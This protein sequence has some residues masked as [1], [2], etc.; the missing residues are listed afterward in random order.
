MLANIGTL[1]AY[2]VSP[3]IY[4]NG[5]SPCG[6]SRGCGI[7]PAE[8]T[9][10][11]ERSAVPMKALVRS[12]SAQALSF[13]E[14]PRCPS[15]E[16]REPK[17]RTINSARMHS[18]DDMRQALTHCTMRAVRRVTSVP[19]RLRKGDDETVSTLAFN[20]PGQ[21][22]RSESVRSPRM[23]PRTLHGAWDDT[24]RNSPPLSRC[25]SEWFRSSRSSSF[26]PRAKPHRQLDSNASVAASD[27]GS[28]T[29]R[30]SRSLSPQAAQDHLWRELF[31]SE[32][33]ERKIARLRG[34]GQ[35][36]GNRGKS[37]VGIPWRQIPSYDRVGLLS[38]TGDPYHAD[39]M[40]HA[41]PM[42][43]KKPS[44][45]SP[46]F[47]SN[48]GVRDLLAPVSENLQPENAP[49]PANPSTETEAASAREAWL[50]LVKRR[51]A[52]KYTG[53]RV[54]DVLQI[55]D[56]SQPPRSSVPSEYSEFEASEGGSGLHWSYVRQRKK[57]MCVV[58]EGST[59]DV[60]PY[61]RDDS[62]PQK[63]V[64]QSATPHRRNNL[65]PPATLSGTGASPKTASHR[66]VDTEPGL[67]AE[68]V[69]EARR[70]FNYCQDKASECGGVSQSPVPSARG[71]T[72]SASAR[73]FP[74]HS[75]RARGNGPQRPRWK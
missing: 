2:P 18:G 34:A 56:A 72:G 44:V 53:T 29:S 15:P 59:K 58:G 67:V 13:E 54:A 75:V 61:S 6:A 71:L 8:R 30:T 27:F 46:K 10:E 38:E 39:Q 21:T 74:V 73:S 49:S 19:P 26:D 11:T 40:K 42:I 65:Q 16:S 25:G 50:D 69:I 7:V 48:S 52:A 31:H 9:L 14:G 43:S 12:A 35:A 55:A 63:R 41:V 66:D 22:P 20:S 64:V 62:T 37:S 17:K 60:C 70:D 1:E 47:T 24:F 33:D 28:R 45:F 51:C 3:S 57:A 4:S 32:A 5:S 23:M 68:R 36:I